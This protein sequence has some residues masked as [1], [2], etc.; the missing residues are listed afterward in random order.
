MKEKTHG[1]ILTLIFMVL[2]G[3]V[4]NAQNNFGSE[5]ELR[6]QAENFFKDDDYA[7]A[8]PL[9]S[10]LLSLYPKDPNFNYKYGVSLLYAKENKEKPLPYLSFAIGKE[11]VDDDIYYHLGRAYHLNYRFDEAIAQ[12]NVFKQK[13]SK[14]STKLEVDLQIRQ[15]ENGKSLLRNVTDL[16]VI[17]KKELNS[18]EYFRAYDL[19]KIAAK[20]VVK[21]DEL[22]TP[23]DIKKK[24][25]STVVIRQTNQE[26]Y[27]SSFGTDGKNGR[28]IYKISKLP[29]F[30]WGQPVN[31]GPNINTNYDEDF[32]YITPDGKTLYFSSKGHNSM[33]GYDVFKA[34]LNPSGEW[35]KPQNL[36]FA[37]NT[38]D[39]DIQYV[40]DPESDFAYFSSKRN[41]ADGKII[42][43]K[44]KTERV[45]VTAAII[46]GKVISDAIPTNLVAKIS[47]KNVQ[48][49]K[50][51][52]TFS[53]SE[54]EGKY[55]LNLNNG[56]K[57]EFTVEQSGTPPITQ[58]VD[59]PPM[60]ELRPLRQEIQLK[61][62]DGSTTMVIYN[63]FSDTVE[64]DALATAELFKERANLDVNYEEQ[65]QA[66][67]ISEASRKPV[68]DNKLLDNRNAYKENLAQTNTEKESPGENKTKNQNEQAKETP[69]KEENTTAS[70]EN[71]TAAKGNAVAAKENNESKKSETGINNS[72]IVTIAKDDAKE[73]QKEADDLRDKSRQ[74]YAFSNLKNN[75][76]QKKYKEAS[77][78]ESQAAT[79][80]DLGEKQTQLD[81]SAK[82]KKEGDNLTQQ[83]AVAYNLAKDLEQEADA[84]QVEANQ[85]DQYA[86]DLDVAV[87]SNSAEALEKLEK[88]SKELE[89][90]QSP[91]KTNSPDNLVKQS[92]DKNEEASRL[93][94]RKNDL[95]AEIQESMFDEKI[96]REEILKAKNDAAK[97]DSESKLKIVLATRK[98]KETELGGIDNKISK[99]KEEALNLEEE[100]RINK[101]ILSEIASSNNA[102]L[103][104]IPEDEKQKL[105]AQFNSQRTSNTVASNVKPDTNSNQPGSSISKQSNTAKPNATANNNSSLAVDDYT[106]FANSFDESKKEMLL[107]QSEQATQKSD[108]VAKKLNNVT[109]QSEITKLTQLQNNYQEIATSKKLASNI[110]AYN[111]LNKEYAANQNALSQK[112]QNLPESD[113]ANFNNSLSQIESDYQ[114]VVLNKENA[115]GQNNLKDKE[116]NFN[117]AINA[118]NVVLVRQRKLLEQANSSIANAQVEN[119][120]ISE[121]KGFNTDRNSSA[122][123]AVN[124]LRPDYTNYKS[125]LEVPEEEMAVVKRST[126]YLQFEGIVNQARVFEEKA[127]KKAVEY[128]TT[129]TQGEEKVI[130]S[131]QLIDL[132]SEEKKKAKKQALAEEAIRVDNE[133]RDLLNKADTIKVQAQNEM[134]KAAAVKA[135]AD[136]FIAKLD[137]AQQDKI[138][139]AYQFTVATPAVE[140]ASTNTENKEEK[141]KVN[142]EKQTENK[143][144]NNTTSEAKASNQEPI[145]INAPNNESKIDE[146]AK[147]QEPNNESKVDET[148]KSQEAN[149]QPEDNKQQIVTSNTNAAPK[150]KDKESVLKEIKAT[151]EYIEYAAIKDEAETL[152][153]TATQKRVEAD[154]IKVQAQRDAINSND[155]FEFAAAQSKKK[156]RKEA[157]KKAEDMD[158]VSKDNEVKADSLNI[159]AEK[160]ESSARM[161]QYEAD[162]FLKKFDDTKSRTLLMAYN[163]TVPEEMLKLEQPAKEAEPVVANNTKANSK[164]E[165]PAKQDP[166]VDKQ[167]NEVAAN[168]AAKENTNLSNSAAT[169]NKTQA[170]QNQQNR[171]LAINNSQQNTKPANESKVEENK[172]AEPVAQVKQAKP[173]VKTTVEYNKFVTLKQE[174]NQ[175]D[176]EAKALKQ[177][178]DSTKA[179]SAQKLD[180][181]NNKLE[182]AAAL[183]KRKRNP[184]VK[185]ATELDYASQLLAREAD[186]LNVFASEANKNAND[187]K[188]A[189]DNYL[190][191]ID[192]DL[193]LRI[194]RSIEGIPEP[195]E[196]EAV[197]EVAINNQNPTLASSNEA[198]KINSPVSVGVQ[199]GKAHST[200]NPI[201]MNE[202]LPDG[203][204]F[205]VQIGAFN[206]PVAENAFG[207][208]SP[209]S[210]EILANSNL[211]RYTAGL[212]R[213]FDDASTARK[214]LNGLNYKDAFVVAYCYGKRISVTEARAL[215]ANGKD[216][217]TGG[218]V[219][220]NQNAIASTSNNKTS[221][222]NSTIT[223]ESSTNTA[224]ES[225]NT[226]NT[227]NAN[228]NAP[229]QIKS[230]ETLPQQDIQAIKGLLYTVQ[231][232]VYS[233]PVKAGQLFNITPLYYELNQKGQFR[234]TS[235]IFNDVKEA[236]KAKDIIVQIGVSDAFVSAYINGKRIP[237]E[238]AAAMEA[239]QGKSVFAQIQGMN[240]QPKIIPLAGS[241]QPRTVIAPET[242][243]E[244][245]KPSNN[246]VANIVYKVQLGAFKN[247]VPVEIM[248]KYLTIAD[249]GIANFK[250]GDLTIY[251]VGN[252]KDAASA[253]A[254]K[255]EVI[256]KGISDAF[257]IALNNGEK[258]S[259]EEAKKLGGK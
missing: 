84:K 240:V 102:N 111:I 78:T 71:P 59:I 12:Y 163:N 160:A 74:A 7:A 209:V 200:S 32:P 44:V 190:S 197:S 183:K 36:D 173:D 60:K 169:E 103:T 203:L 30:T 129:K 144:Q 224:A 85:A 94:E 166:K 212:F 204:V 45:P 215:M 227:N 22:K 96:A 92:Q 2:I 98:D 87:K 122:T 86:N 226:N 238:Q 16:T 252:Y 110:I 97:D 237:M 81:A 113:K 162:N 165:A 42:V 196:V 119:K 210:G 172:T 220:S 149:K 185:E 175:A 5:K 33:G 153:V 21:P 131:Q 218:Q 142:E 186:S 216:C 29:N 11:D 158:R 112:S 225:S 235:G 164:V 51:L 251:T 138:L 228:L 62:K 63:F 25:Q 135:E 13:K 168:N 89:K 123:E 6:K 206:R 143:E 178:V 258:I 219:A 242:K 67:I 134:L 125:T 184:L 231:V 69:V 247:E 80:N 167:N 47:I 26:I 100:A 128:S 49:G 194:M 195:V 40:T 137:K 248:N 182:E 127:D 121:F 141:A 90:N 191:S 136:K 105:D 56:A 233:K 4:A 83:A 70:K 223:T 106:A 174:A 10:Q 115:L 207:S 188:S 148:A 221:N 58:F 232:G 31:L 126:E 151:T 91:S 246:V 54:R 72:E 255:T 146:T 249:K 9:Y 193:A 176:T 236:V 130:E 39:D 202:S 15:C 208:V 19:N 230:G 117:T 257:V 23:L 116:S 57:Y 253:E 205:K 17:E 64:N 82:A 75:A 254:I 52:G 114:K 93:E 24:D 181:S 65:V 239:Q 46:K 250:S 145:A 95:K 139:A 38:P 104:Q 192:K 213:A 66:G 109:E 34:E 79:I 244:A 161:K 124:N 147:N 18:S 187:K 1:L 199:K 41:S 229:A 140:I 154:S 35:N 170:N 37:V 201:K 76:G 68:V 20:L 8:L 189:A 43:F 55:R 171:E 107:K 177:R 150:T 61:K 214:E 118:Q 157:Q 3:F 179:L 120:A 256:A 198:N 156:D 132:A 243:I 48:T 133:G 27:Y 14:I 259:L 101:E 217:K 50:F 77:D 180:E 88:Q 245:P 159:L 53:S 28:D 73:T 155:L 152:K 211:I 99:L 234:Y 222:Q 108:S 241:I